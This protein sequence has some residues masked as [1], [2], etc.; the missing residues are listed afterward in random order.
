MEV[1]LRGDEVLTIVLGRGAVLLSLGLLDFCYRF[2]ESS[3]CFDPSLN[4]T[5]VDLLNLRLTDRDLRNR[6]ASV[7]LD[8][9]EEGTPLFLSCEANIDGEGCVVDG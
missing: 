8:F 6:G 5:T 1:L 7:L 4:A 3:G 9:L 2:S